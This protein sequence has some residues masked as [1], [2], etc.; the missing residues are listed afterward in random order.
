M[1]SCQAVHGHVII[2]AAASYRSGAKSFDTL[3][4][5]TRSIFFCKDAQSV[6]HVRV[7]HVDVD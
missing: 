7:E 3:V 6:T 5:S 1:A 4:A 2:A